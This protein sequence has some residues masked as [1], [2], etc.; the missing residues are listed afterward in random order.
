MFSYL[1]TLIFIVTSFTF[2]QFTW[3]VDGYVYLEDS[4]NSEGVLINFYNLIDSESND[5]YSD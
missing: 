1:C 3:H 4:E 5:I 2:A